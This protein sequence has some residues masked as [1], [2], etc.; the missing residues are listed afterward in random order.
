[1][2]IAHRRIGTGPVR[3][4][5]LHDWFGTSANW[6]PYWTTWTRRASA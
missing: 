4:I 5:V 6:V 2:A 1:M 3:V